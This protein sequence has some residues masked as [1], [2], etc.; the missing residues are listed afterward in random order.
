[1]SAA[2]G[3]GRSRASNSRLK[4]S[5]VTTLYNS[6]GTIEEFYRRAVAAAEAIGGKFKIVMVDEGS[7]DDSLSLTCRIAQQDERVRVIE[8][9]RNFGH[10]KALMTGLDYARGEL[11]SSLTAILFAFDIVVACRCTASGSHRRF[12]R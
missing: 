11:L 1:M 2:L 4:L 7:P 9:S 8:L 5:I 10:H 6:S 12:A 3:P